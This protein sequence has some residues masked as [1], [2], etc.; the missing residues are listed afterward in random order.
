MLSKNCL[1]IASSVA[2]NLVDGTDV[3]L[4]TIGLK[5]RI[6]AHQLRREID[7]SLLLYVPSAK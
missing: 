6:D 7:R 3:V 4:N 2:R 5:C 1:L